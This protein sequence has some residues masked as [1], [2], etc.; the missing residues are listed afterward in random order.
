[1]PFS[2]LIV[3]RQYRAPP[4]T[5]RVVADGARKRQRQHVMMPCCRLS[6]SVCPCSGVL[7]REDYQPV[8]DQ[9]EHEDGHRQAALKGAIRIPMALST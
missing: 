9:D 8:G 2:N 4:N 5:G 6:N 3:V 1:M 7:H